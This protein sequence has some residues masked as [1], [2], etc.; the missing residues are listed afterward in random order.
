MQTACK[1]TSHAN[2]FLQ[3][4]DKQVKAALVAM[5]MQAEGH[6]K[7][8]LTNVPERIDTGLLRNSITWALSGE[9]ANISSYSGDNPSRRNPNG[10]IPKGTYAGQAPEAKEHNFAVWIG[11]NVEYATYV[12]DG[13]IKMAANKFIKNAITRYRKEYKQIAKEYL[14]GA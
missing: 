5:G 10:E 2:L 1:L 4:S 7:V 14:K 3:A 8:E 6:A 11:T 12:H 13:T 9:S